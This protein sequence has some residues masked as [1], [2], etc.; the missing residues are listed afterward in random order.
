MFGEWSQCNASQAKWFIGHGVNLDLTDEKGLTLVQHCELLTN[1]GNE[2]EDEYSVEQATNILELLY[3]QNRLDQLY[4]GLRKI[5]ESFEQLQQFIDLAITEYDSQDLA[6]TVTHTYIDQNPDQNKITVRKLLQSDDW[7]HRFVAALVLQSAQLD[8]NAATSMIL[9][10]FGDTDNDVVQGLVGAMHQYGLPM[11]ESILGTLESCP[12]SG[13][14]L[15]ATVLVDIDSDRTLDVESSYSA[16]LPQNMETLDG[17]ERLRAGIVVG[18]LGWFAGQREEFDKAVQLCEKSVALNP[19]VIQGF[20]Y[21]LGEFKSSLG[22]TQLQEA[23]LSYYQMKEADD[24]ETF[25]ALREDAIIKAPEFLWPTN[26]LAWLLATAADPDFRDGER[27]VVLAKSVCDQSNWN[28]WSFI[29]TLAAAYA[30]AGD[31]PN[32]VE[33]AK[34]AYAI[35]AVADHPSIQETISRYE[36]EESW[37]FPVEEEDIDE[38]GDDED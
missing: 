3:D 38:G 24:I 8:C 34:K 29:D 4:G 35:A 37:P 32:A 25:Q 27:A 20:W 33:T 1:S 23:I 21:E 28:Y 22:D 11:A 14:Q 10:H 26:D 9:D 18:V 15:L 5:P 16:M 30:E 17:A 36:G 12:T 13:L 19:C 6:N 31:F 2:D 7:R